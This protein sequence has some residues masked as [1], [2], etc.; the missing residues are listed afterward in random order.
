MENETR[1]N[2]AFPRK[3]MTGRGGIIDAVSGN[4]TPI[5]LLDISVGGVSFLSAAAYAKGSMRLVRFELDGKAVRGVVCIVYCV[6]HSLADA[7]RLG[8]KFKD[9][10]SQ[11]LKTI[12]DYLD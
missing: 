1:E 7:Y 11:Y 2:R 10:E 8:A 4:M 6:K 9:L 3:R 5:D 12:Q